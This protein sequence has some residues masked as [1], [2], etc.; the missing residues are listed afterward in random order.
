MTQVLGLWTHG[1]EIHNIPNVGDPA[2]PR[3]SFFALGESDGVA[4]QS[5]WRLAVERASCPS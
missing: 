2:A 3:L 4:L 1:V 5:F